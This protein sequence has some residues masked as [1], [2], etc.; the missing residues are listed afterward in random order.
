MSIETV[1]GGPVLDPMFKIAES[2]LKGAGSVGGVAEDLIKKYKAEKNISDKSLG[3]KVGGVLAGFEKLPKYLKALKLASVVVATLVTP[4]KVGSEMTVKDL[5]S[6]HT[7]LVTQM[8]ERRKN[9]TESF[10]L[11]Q[12]EVQ[13]QIDDFLNE[14]RLA[15]KDLVELVKKENPEKDLTKFTITELSLIIFFQFVPKGI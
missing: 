9:E 6:S 14:V 5:G 8:A 1:S 15:A 11:G 7:Q 10:K 2:W 3:A 13:R 4:V 12:S